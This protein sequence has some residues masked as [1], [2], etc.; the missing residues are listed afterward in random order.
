MFPM[1]RDI[2]VFLVGFCY[3]RWTRLKGV[4]GV[5]PVISRY[6]WEEDE[7]DDVDEYPDWEEGSDCDLRPPPELV[8]L[9][10]DTEIEMVG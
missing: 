5:I 6:K 9:A 1:K 3:M 10:P 8:V 4:G 7:L 2:L